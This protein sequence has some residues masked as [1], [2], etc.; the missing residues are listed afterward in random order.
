MS[1]HILKFWLVQIFVD[2]S[3]RPS[4]EIF[5]VLNFA[6]VLDLVL[7]NVHED[8]FHSSYFHGSGTIHE[9]REILQRENFPLYSIHSGMNQSQLYDVHVHSTIHQLVIPDSMF[10][11]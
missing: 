6:P 5:V 11:W 9:N 10:L 3:S 8:I 4:E 7:A 2:L 1:S